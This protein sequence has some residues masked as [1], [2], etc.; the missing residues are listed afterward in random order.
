MNRAP[1][2]L[3]YLNVLIIATCGL[4]Y[5]LLAG[6]LA[7]MQPF[8]TPQRLPRYLDGQLKFL[9]DGSLPAMFELSPDVSAVPVEINR[10]NNQM[11]VRYYEQESRRWN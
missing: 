6:T 7:S 9:N 11:L 2:F 1:L 5:E 10:L 8:N 4:I 3:L